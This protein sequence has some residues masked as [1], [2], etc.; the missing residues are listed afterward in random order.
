L[1]VVVY[2]PRECRSKAGHVRSAIHRVD[3]VGERMD[4]LV[5]AVVIL[6]RDFDGERLC[7]R[8]F[9]I[10]VNWMSVQ[11]ALILVQMLYEFRDSALVKELVRLLGSLIVDADAYTGVQEG[12]LAQPLRKSVE[13]EFGDFKDFRIRLKRNFRPAPFRLARGLKPCRGY[14]ANVL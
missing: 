11:Y 13:V 7:C 10:E 5:V 12:L 3:V 8:R 6:D 2:R 1:G 4:D 14:P 9:A